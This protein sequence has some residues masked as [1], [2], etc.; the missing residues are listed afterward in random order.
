[1]KTLLFALGVLT[2]GGCFTSGEVQQVE[3]TNAELVKIDTVYRYDDNN[4]I[5]N[6]WLPEQQLTWR[7]SYNN[8]Y[9]CFASLEQT[10]VVGTKMAVLRRK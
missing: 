2:L 5:D 9:I 4:K 7:D 1:M 8:T 3:V 10:Y 6:V